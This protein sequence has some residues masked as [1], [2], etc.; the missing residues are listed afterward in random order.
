VRLAVKEFRADY[1]FRFLVN[2]HLHFY[3]MSFFLPDIL[4]NV[5]VLTP[6]TCRKRSFLNPFI[7]CPFIK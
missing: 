6:V 2:D 1:F 3:R 7:N 5:S 4:L